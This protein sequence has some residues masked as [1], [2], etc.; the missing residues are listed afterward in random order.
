MTEGSGR[1]VRRA[2]LVTVVVVVLLVL[3]AGRTLFMRQTNAKTLEANTGDHAKLYVKVTKPSVGGEG[4]TVVLPGSLQGESQ[5]PLS[6]RTSG[7]LKKWTKDIGTTVEKGDVLA[8]I[9]SP[10]IDQQLTR[11]WRSRRARWPAGRHCGRRTWWR[12]RSWTRSAPAL[13]RRR[14]TSRPRMPTSIA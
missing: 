9:E 6:S 11:A 5:A 3:G 12:S 13:R 7:Y 8:E 4:Q 1:A 10:E 14:P 2:K